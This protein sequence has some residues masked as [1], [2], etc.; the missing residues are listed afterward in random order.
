MQSRRMRMVRQ[1]Y[2]VARCA[3]LCCAARVGVRWQAAV[4]TGA[5]HSDSQPRHK[6][7]A[8]VHQRN[9]HTFAHA[10]LP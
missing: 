8:G 10:C 2:A 7:A 9:Q 3:V 1:S 4:G 6:I 5:A